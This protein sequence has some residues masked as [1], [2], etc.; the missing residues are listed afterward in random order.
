MELMLASVQVICFILAW[1]AISDTG[2][3]QKYLL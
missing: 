2:A 1:G 3:Q